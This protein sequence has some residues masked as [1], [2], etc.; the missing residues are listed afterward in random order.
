MEWEAA[1]SG[2]QCQER[3]RQEEEGDK[4][5]HLRKRESQPAQRLETVTHLNL[6]QRNWNVNSPAWGVV[7]SFAASLAVVSSHASDDE[8]GSGT[9][10]AFDFAGY[11]G[12]SFDFEIEEV[13]EVQPEL[14]IGLEVARQAQGGVRGN[15]S[16]LMHN[17][18]DTRRRH[19]QL[20]RQPVDGEAER[21]HEVLAQDLAG[22]HGRQEIVRLAYM[23]NSSVKVLGLFRAKAPDHP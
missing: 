12:T 17:L 22:M 5:C 19:V 3:V 11:A 6:R 21:F 13:L 7:A 14:S 16:A 9:D 1:A 18:A 23:R 2:S 10:P 15:A 8:R 20:K 4:S